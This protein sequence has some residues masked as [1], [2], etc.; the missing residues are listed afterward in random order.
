[1]FAL[2]YSVFDPSRKWECIAAFR[3]GST[4]FRLQGLE[5][6]AEC[7]GTPMQIVDHSRPVTRLVG[8]GPGIDIVHSVSHSIVE[9]NCDLAGRGGHGLGLADAR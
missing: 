6:K 3:N 7:L 9:Q 5:N 1:M 4:Y 2:S 8:P